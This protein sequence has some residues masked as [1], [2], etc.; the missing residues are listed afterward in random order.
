MTASSYQQ[1]IET[2]KRVQWTVASVLGDETF[3]LGKPFLPESLAQVSGLE[4]L[5]AAEKL[6]LNQ[7]RGLTY[8]HL[9]G[10]VEEFILKK[11]IE[12]SASYG[13][14]R[15]VERH[16]L[17]VFS[18]EEAK[19]QLLFE[20]TKAALERQLGACDL[21][22]GADDVAGFVLQ[23]SQLCVLL[24]T[25][26]LEWTTQHHYV[27]IFRSAEE[28][29]VLD[30]TF[31]AI[32]KAHWVEEAQHTKLDHLEILRAAEG[33]SAEEREAA[34]DQLLEIGG[35]FDG[36]LQAQAQLDLASLQ[37]HIGR[38]LS[39]SDK[40]LILARQHKA[41]RHTF[42]VT[43]LRHPKFLEQVASLTRGGTDKLA[44]AADAL[45]A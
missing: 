28:R 12:L 36:L 33:T 14:D 25:S 5:S 2:S 43:A 24:L 1:L 16:A 40:E 44:Q 8:A 39:A 23:K 32:F 35:A 41:Y 4:C 11:V 38:T 27:D 13:F 19:H 42:L 37:R 6:R 34:V 45:S 3:D 22:P 18:E 29:E 10:F 31:V 17:L 15:A 26:M 9:F 21:V 20:R 30:P 7:I